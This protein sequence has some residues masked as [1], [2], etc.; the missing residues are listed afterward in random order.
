MKTLKRNGWTVKATNT[1]IKI[2]IKL[3]NDIEYNAG[4]FAK[5]NTPT[6]NRVVITESKIETL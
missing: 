4:C 1:V 3:T 6:P 5:I 2:P